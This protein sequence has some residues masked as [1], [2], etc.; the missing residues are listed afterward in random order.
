MFCNHFDQNATECLAYFFS[1][2][3]QEVLAWGGD[4]GFTMRSLLDVASR[5]LLSHFTLL[6]FSYWGSGNL[7]TGFMQ[8]SRPRFGKLWI[9][10]CWKLHSATYFASALTNGTTY[11]RSGCC[12]GQAFAIF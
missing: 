7:W 8:A 6:R 4:P 3:K 10:F 2:A 1:G 12:S 5:C 9:T 11:Q